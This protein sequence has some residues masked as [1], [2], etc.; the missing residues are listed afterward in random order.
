MRRMLSLLCT[1]GACAGHERSSNEQAVTNGTI[2]TGDPAV[3]ALVDANDQVGCTATVIGSHTAIT[4]AHCFVSRPPRSLRVYFGTQLGDGGTFI[5]VSDARSHPDFDFSVLS[6]DI[7]MLTLRD[8][9]PAAPVALDMRTLDSSLV[10]TDFRVVGFGTT[11]GTTGDAGTKREGIAR[12]SD[13]AGLE[14]T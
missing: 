14:F 3:I 11:T 1:L 5:A 6:N 2:A 4:A 7:A 9:S 12:M 8:E 13:V 10:G